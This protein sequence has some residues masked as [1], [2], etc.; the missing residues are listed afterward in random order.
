MFLNK[1][2][3]VEN[4][5]EHFVKNEHADSSRISEPVLNSYENLFRATELERC[6]QLSLLTG[7]V[8]SIYAMFGDSILKQVTDNAYLPKSSTFYY[9][10]TYARSFDV[11]D[12]ELIRNV[13]VNRDYLAKSNAT[14][15]V[16][17]ITYGTR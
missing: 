12:P 10:S 1:T 6:Q 5:S 14:H 3:F 13:T 4:I 17:K 15:Y 9:F 11:H 16:S 2:L 8:D 7:L